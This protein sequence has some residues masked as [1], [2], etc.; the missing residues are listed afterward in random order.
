MQDIAVTLDAETAS[1]STVH[2][3]LLNGDIKLNRDRQ[4]LI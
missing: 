1:F 4:S 3:S 2:I